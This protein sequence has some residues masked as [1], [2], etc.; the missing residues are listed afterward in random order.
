M[1]NNLKGLDAPQVL[2]SVYDEDPNALRV[3][4]INGTGGSGASELEVLI[5]HT[6]DSVRLGDGVKFI[7]STS[8][9]AKTALDV[10]VI[11]GLTPVVGSNVQNIFNEVQS[12][13]SGVYTQILTFTA[14]DECQLKKVVCSGDNI[15]T[16]DIQVNSDVQSKQRTYFGGSLNCKFDFEEGLLLE[17][18]DTIE[19]YVVHNRPSIGDF[20]SNI[21]ILET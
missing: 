11:N 12:V 9:G 19:V 4:V 1:A 8:S 21:L 5:D 16:Y 2:R 18:G 17:P 13:A 20:N 15:A 6:E 14:V 7:T 10:N 3:N